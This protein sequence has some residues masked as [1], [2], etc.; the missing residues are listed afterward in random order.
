LTKKLSLEELQRLSLSEYKSKDKN[1]IILLADNIRSGHNIGSLFRI[2]DSFGFQAVDL[3]G[4]SVKPPHPEIN[5]TAIGATESVTWSAIDDIN[6]YVEKKISQGYKIIA[7]E[8]TTNSIPL[9]RFPINVN[10]KYILIFGNEVHGVSDDIIKLT[11]HFIEIP[12]FGTKHSLNVSVAAG[13]VAWH[14]L[15]KILLNK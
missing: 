14:F 8:Q 10:E 4:C 9:H 1:Q 6:T 7:I 13:I 15:E 5:K 11:N 12:Q 3:Y 2:A